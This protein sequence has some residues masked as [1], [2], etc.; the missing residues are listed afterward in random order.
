MATSHEIKEQSTSTSDVP[1]TELYV[2]TSYTG[3]LMDNS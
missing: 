1:S 2:V 3:G